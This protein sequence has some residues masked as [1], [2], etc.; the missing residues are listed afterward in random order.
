MNGINNLP[1]SY[2]SKYT[3]GIGFAI[4]LPLIIISLSLDNIS[5]FV[6]AM[7]R[8]WR[9]RKR[10]LRNPVGQS[11][12][13]QTLDLDLRIE[14]ALSSRKSGEKDQLSY[15]ERLAS[16]NTASQD[17]PGFKER[18]IKTTAFRLRHSGDVERGY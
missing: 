5:D 11:I 8:K 1:L 7:R 3:F 2:V 16:R 6:R 4:S 9:H 10:R 13:E 18:A 15:L 14:E 17:V 12:D